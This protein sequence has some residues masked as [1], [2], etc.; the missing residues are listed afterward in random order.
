MPYH[1]L[2]GFVGFVWMSTATASTQTD[3]K[4]R[5][6]AQGFGE[7]PVSSGSFGTQGTKARVGDWTIAFPTN[8][9]NAAIYRDSGNLAVEVIAGSVG[10]FHLRVDDRECTY[11]TSGGCDLKTTSVFYARPYTSTDRGERVTSRMQ[12]TLADPSFETQR[13]TI[14]VEP[15]SIRVKL[16]DGANLSFEANARTIRYISADGETTHLP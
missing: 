7:A 5:N 2:V 6:E 1:W 3:L 16:H 15:T 11:H 14:Y 4:R 12:V 10:W 8:S 9:H 13:S